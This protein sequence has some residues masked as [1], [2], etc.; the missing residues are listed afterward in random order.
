MFPF[1]KNRPNYDRIPLKTLFTTCL[2]SIN[3]FFTQAQRLQRLGISENVSCNIC[4]FSSGHTVTR[5]AGGHRT[6]YAHA[7]DDT[8]VRAIQG[9]P[10]LKLVKTAVQLFDDEQLA[11]V[12]LVMEAPKIHSKI[13]RNIFASGKVKISQKLGF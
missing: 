5:I 11:E 6:P 3:Y 10:N 8:A 4:I 13:P 2:Q 1:K 12:D 9:Q 7:F